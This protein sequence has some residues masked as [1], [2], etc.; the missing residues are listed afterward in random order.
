MKVRLFKLLL[1]SS[2]ILM[3]HTCN[4]QPAPIYSFEKSISLPGDEGYDYLSIDE[5]NKHLFVSHGTSVN[6]IDLNTSQLIGSVDNMKGV[7]GIAICNSVNKGFITDGKDNSVVVFDLKTF[8]IITTISVT[9]KGP[10]GIIFDSFSKKIFAFCGKGNAASVID[11]TQLKEVGVVDLGGGP[12]FAVSDGKGLIYNNL[13]DKNS[14]DVIDTKTLKVIKNF[15]LL[16]CGGPTGLA[17]DLQHG[18]L[19]TVCRENKGM[20]VVNIKTGTVIATLPI[21]AGVDAVVYDES[22]KLILCSN[23]DST[24]TIIK[25]SSADDYAVVQTLKTQMRAKT[26]ALDKVTHKIY[27]SAPRFET[28][29]RKIMPGTFAVWIYKMN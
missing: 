3:G 8:K 27:L 6:I 28:G 22:T 11:I 29:T 21:G 24:T 13:E 26:M 5:I 25:Q 4:A 16:P 19:F 14:L 17:L 1:I 12:E 23:G 10:D 20:S 2:V 15:P 18:R 9:P 7:H